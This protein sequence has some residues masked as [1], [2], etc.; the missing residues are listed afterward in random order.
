LI[1]DLVCTK[2]KQYT[3][4]QTKCRIL[5]TESNNATMQ[6]AS[7]HADSC[8]E[9]KEGNYSIHWGC[10]WIW[11]CNVCRGLYAECNICILEFLHTRSWYGQLI[12]NLV[13]TKWKQYTYLQTKLFMFIA[14]SI[15]HINVVWQV[16]E[17]LSD[18]VHNHILE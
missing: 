6:I 2:W 15:V 17:W 13:C 8:E 10:I 18:Y 12:S 5:L 3:Y 14:I 11:I 16:E 9:M 7:S 4:L 1:L